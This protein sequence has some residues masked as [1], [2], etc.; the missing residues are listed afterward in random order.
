VAALGATAVTVLVSGLLLGRREAA[1][2]GR[3]APAPLAY[4]S[5]KGYVCGRAAG[6]LRFDGRLDDAAW[7][8]APWTD[9]FVD[10]EGDRKPRPRFR[11][12]A[13]MLW[14]DE[15]FYVGAEMEEPHVWGT[16]TRHDSV[17]FH[18]NDFEVFIDPQHRLGPAPGASV[19]G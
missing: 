19:Q 16:L 3:G 7:Q 1:D 5:P 2:E 15:F 14:D 4:P 17:I 13:K 12:R 8:A 18:D 6:S 11:T 9:A 10:I